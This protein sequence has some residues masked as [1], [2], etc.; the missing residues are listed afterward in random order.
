MATPK[1]LAKSL[2]KSDWQKRAKT[3]KI[4]YEDKSTV[5]YLV[6]KIA[7]KISVDDKIVNDD[8]L[9]TAVYIKLE[10]MEK[11]RAKEDAAK[12][13]ELEKK[14]AAKKKAAPKKKAPAKKVAAKKTA[15]KKPAAKKKAPAKKAV[16][17]KKVAE[18]FEKGGTAPKKESKAAVPLTEEQI[19]EL[20]RD[21]YRGQAQI[22]GLNF[23]MEQT[24]KDI[25]AIIQLHK[26]QFSHVQYKEFDLEAA[27]AVKNAPPVVPAVDKE[28]ADLRAKCTAV[29]IAYNE[30]HTVI[31]LRQLVGAI[32][33][34]VA[35]A[36][37]PADAVAA[38][39]D[40]SLEVNMD[41]LEELTS[42][43]PAKPVIPSTQVG[44]SP[45][46]LGQITAAPAEDP[47][48]VNEKQLIVYRD[49]FNQAIQAHF[50]VM[51]RAEIAEM[52]SAGYPF[53]YTVQNHPTNANQLEIMLASGEHVVRVP[54]EDKNNWITVN[55]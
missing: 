46:F 49:S 45:A 9:K 3:F 30:A 24:S 31:D 5:R 1:S 21:H 43:A 22:L 42:E 52:L 40:G 8:D 47:T 34:G 10:E 55:G 39:V 36:A 6:E 18:A 25:M 51:S 15:P 35:P 2:S 29:G 23:G 37:N 26:K 19:E 20:K 12:A 13:K 33:A 4:K 41:N 16:D 32:P 14:P 7:E 11:A 44:Q 38:S 27:I 48:S 50:R 28:L 54:N 53:T 17:L